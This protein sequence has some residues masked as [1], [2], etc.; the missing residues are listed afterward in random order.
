MSDRKI[1]ILSSIA[2]LVISTIYI[3][4]SLETQTFAKANV[5]HPE[6]D[7]I[8]IKELNIYSEEDETLIPVDISY[9]DKEKLTDLMYTTKVSGNPVKKPS[10]TTLIVEQEFINSRSYYLGF[11]LHKKN[12]NYYVAVPIDDNAEKFGEDWYKLKST[13]IPDF[14]F[15]LLEK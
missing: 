9:E 8:T 12:N 14:Y 4:R 10:S 2:L 13:E 1:M 15:Y 6:D 3:V 7:F 11:A 5:M